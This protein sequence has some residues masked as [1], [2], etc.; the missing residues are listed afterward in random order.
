MTE[1]QIES[2]NRRIRGI[3]FDGDVNHPY[4]LAHSDA[5]QLTDSLLKSRYF[6]YRSENDAFDES[7]AEA[8]EEF[9][10]W[11]EDRYGYF[12]VITTSEMFH[13]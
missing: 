8:F 1:E 4:L 6:E 5:M 12:K 10:S 13:F 3:S 2:I 11:L 7:D 9:L